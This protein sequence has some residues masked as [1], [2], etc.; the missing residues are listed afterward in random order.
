MADSLVLRRGDKIPSG[1]FAEF[2]GGRD[3]HHRIFLRTADK[4]LRSVYRTRK[5]R[6]ATKTQVNSGFSQQN[7]V[8]L[9]AVGKV[10]SDLPPKSHDEMA[11][12]SGKPSLMGS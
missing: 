5:I 9:L 1:M 11:A 4:E 2:A 12:M 7:T 3:M 10:R 8:G 6:D